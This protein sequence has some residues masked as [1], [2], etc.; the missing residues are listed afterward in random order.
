MANAT[1]ALLRAIIAHLMPILRLLAILSLVS[2]CGRTIEQRP[3]SNL[4]TA[5]QSLALATAVVDCEWKAAAHN[6]DGRSSFAA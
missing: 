1:V 5:D 2:A 4:P 6:D 3:I